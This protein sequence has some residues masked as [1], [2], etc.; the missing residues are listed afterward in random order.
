MNSIITILRTDPSR[1]RLRTLSFRA[2]RGIF[3][4]FIILASS[5]EKSVVFPADK[6]GRIHISAMLG[7]GEQDRIDVTVSRPVMG[8]ETLSADAVSLYLEADGTPV[9]LNKGEMQD[10]TVSYDL[11][12]TF[13]TGQKI[14]LRAEAEGLPSV[15]AVTTVPKSLPQVRIEPRV[16]E[17]Y[18]DR[19]DAQNMA[20][21]YPVR[22]FHV[23]LDEKPQ[24]NSY[25]AVQVL[26]KTVYDIIGAPSDRILEK[27]LS[28][29]GIVKYDDLYSNTSP[30]EGGAIS[31]MEKE[32]LLEYS[33]GEML[34][35]P[36][37]NEDGK[38]VLDVYVAITERRLVSA[39]YTNT[40]GEQFINHEI[41]E[42]FEYDVKIYRLSPELYHCMRARYIVDKS[43]A[44]IHLGFT[45]VTYTYTNVVGG[46][47]MFGAV[48]MYETG[49][50]RIN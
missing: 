26:R 14:L 17:S 25:F 39:S 11:E 7:T 44:P 46:L 36:V 5:C 18:R 16:V 35:A 9:A 10:G 4:C 48:S 1:S 33:G 38:S 22:N 32:M 30:T 23:V 40:G 41:Y 45:P 20:D 8:N 19:D 3:L 42:D 37:E 27:Y 24:D 12:G 43:D 15:K 13:S 6:D 2:C 31:S 50:F 34:V 21:L 29:S 47:G 28:M 49:W